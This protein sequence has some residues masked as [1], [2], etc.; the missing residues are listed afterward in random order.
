MP[1]DGNLTLQERLV[2]V[3]R[4]VSNRTRL[5]ILA[6]GA[7]SFAVGTTQIASELDLSPG[8]VAR[9]AK[10]LEKVGLVGIRPRRAVSIHCR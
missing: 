2:V 8:V 9:H 3:A 6:K 7:P 5:E 4:A 10:V 1:M